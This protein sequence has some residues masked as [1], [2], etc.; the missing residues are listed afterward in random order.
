MWTLSFPGVW[1]HILVGNEKLLQH[2]WAHVPAPLLPVPGSDLQAGE[3]GG[4][5]QSPALSRAL[6]PRVSG[7]GSGWNMWC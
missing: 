3:E 6:V 1:R 5:Q 2:S 7:S 4:G